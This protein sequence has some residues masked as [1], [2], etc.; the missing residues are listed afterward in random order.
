MAFCLVTVIVNF[1]N[2]IWIDVVQFILPENLEWLFNIGTTVLNGG[3]SM[4]VFFIV[5]KIVFNDSQT[6][7]KE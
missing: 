5:T 7:E 3:I 4:V 2:C 6:P 1:V